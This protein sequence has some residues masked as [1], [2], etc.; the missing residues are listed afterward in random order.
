MG[1]SYPRRMLFSGHRK[2][3]VAM[4]FLVLALV[5]LAA[6]VFQGAAVFY[7]TVDELV[8]GEADISTTVRVSGRLQPDSFRRESGGTVAHF[9]LIGGGEI[10]PAVHDGVFPELFF[11]EH[12]DIVLEGRYG[13]DGVFRTTASPLVSCPSKYQ[14]VTEEG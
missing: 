11:S 10:L 6:T 12:S 9:N 8:G 13:S 3:Y 4:V 14:A 2:L 1:S 7:F 5:Y